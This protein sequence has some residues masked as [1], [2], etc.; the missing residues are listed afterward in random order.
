MKNTLLIAALAVT[1]LGF[2]QR[3]E[4][5]NIGEAVKKGDFKEA[6][7]EFNEIKESEVESKYLA[8]YKF[9]KAAVM[10]GNPK[11][12]AASGDDLKQIMGYLM[13]AEKLGFDDKDQLTS[14]KQT[15]EETIIKN[16]QENYTSGNKK[17]ALDA[18]IYLVELDPSNLKMKGVAA[19]MAYEV[20]DFDM[21]KTFYEELVKQQYTGISETVVATN[22]ETGE[23]SVFP[24]KKAAEFAIVS[25][26]FK[27]LKIEKSDSQIGSIITNLAWIYK[28]EGQ[29]EKAKKLFSD[30]L[31]KYP[32]D[33]SLKTASADI[34]LILEM[35]DEYEKAIKELNTEIK[36][37]I[38]FENLGAAAAEKE[39]WDQAIDY[40]KKSIELD[41]NN[42]V[43]R[44]NIAVAYI[45]KGNLKETTVEGQKELYTEAALSLEKVIELKPDLASAKQTLL[46]IYKFLN[47]NEKAT[48]LEAKM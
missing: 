22:V 25:K 23:V 36:D 31:N 20:G 43:T 8:D 1:T 6:T 21:A 39:N 27:D 40:Y 16:L 2:A 26:K 32:S 38:V 34:Y 5:K 44:N 29:L 42:Y 24:N 11:N 41:P 3:R 15:V 47:M 30:A 33:M 19:T 10:L 7:A 45:N 17:A 37:P 28:N 14:Y 4:L 9:Y 18:V 48:A 46:G 12:V 13:E 35:D